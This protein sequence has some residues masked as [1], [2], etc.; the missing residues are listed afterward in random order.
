MTK[1]EGPTSQTTRVG[2]IN[3]G[4]TAWTMWL[5]PRSY[6]LWLELR[7]D[8]QAVSP[9]QLAVDLQFSQESAVSA[10]C[11]N[12]VPNEGLTMSLKCAAGALI[13]SCRQ[14]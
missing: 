4:A 8:T 13:C 1:S 7:S 14:T 12:E 5:C 6:I 9:S 10:G 3:A 2:V 11:S